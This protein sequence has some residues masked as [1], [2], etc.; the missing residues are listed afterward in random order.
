MNNDFHFELIKWLLER[1]RNLMAS[2]MQRASLIA[3]ADALLLSGIAFL[4]KDVSAHVGQLGRTKLLFTIC[5]GL[6]LILILTS[7]LYAVSAAGHSIWKK[8][9][10]KYNI[11]YKK[12]LFFSPA[13]RL[14][15]IREHF[16]NQYDFISYLDFFEKEFNQANRDEMIR[17]AIGALLYDTLLHLNS[18]N[19]LRYAMRLLFIAIIPLSI[20]FFCMYFNFIIK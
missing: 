15:H 11:D 1:E 20:A 16:N 8:P 2:T 7:I 13:A 3:S 12:T 6:V 5:T 9:F 17:Y 19:N 18:W 10:K 4:I 14:R